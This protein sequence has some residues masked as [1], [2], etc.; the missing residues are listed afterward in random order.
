M[1]QSVALTPLLQT[2]ILYRHSPSPFF[3]FFP[4]YIH[5]EKLFLHFQ[6]TFRRLKNEVTRF[7]YNYCYKI[8]T[9]SMKS[10]AYSPPYHRQPFYTDYPPHFY[11]K[12]L[13]LPPSPQ[14]F[15]VFRKSQPPINNGGGR[16]S[17]YARGVT[18]TKQNL[19]A[20]KQTLSF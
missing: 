9:L 11:K 16:A 5:V 2:S 6:F 7:F 15:I 19:A 20:G 8:H 14:Y 3:I 4:K 12:M 13:T 1:S 18:V 17:H 10:S